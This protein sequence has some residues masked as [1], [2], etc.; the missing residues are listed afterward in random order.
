MAIPHNCLVAVADGRKLLL[1]HNEGDD[2]FPNLKVI[3]KEEQDNPP[4][5]EQGTD[6]PGRLGDTSL[7]RSAVESTDFHQIEEDR[8]ADNVA[9][10]LYKRAHAGKFDKLILVAPPRVLGRLRDTLHSEVRQRLIAELDK[11]LTKHPP[12][13][14]E[15][16][17]TASLK[18][19]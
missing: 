14:I 4:T 6:R 7:G 17:L 8:F 16:V 9:D 18:A 11:D 3:A 15:E 19:A 10:I 13:K 1:L 5:R 12:A 2:Q